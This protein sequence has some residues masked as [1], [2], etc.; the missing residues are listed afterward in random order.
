MTAIEFS[1]FMDYYSKVKQRTYK[2]IQKIP[3][4]KIDWT[5]REGKFT[6]GDLVRHMAAIERFMYAENAQFKPS[7]YSGCGKELADG[8]ESIV[9][10]FTEMNRQS[11]EIFRKLTTDDLNK[12][13]ITPAG[14][15]ITLWKWLRLMG[16]HEIHHRG[17]IFIYLS[18]LGVQTDPLY[19]LTSEQV[20]MRRSG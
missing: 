19:G 5:F 17:Q 10:F 2:I 8:Y 15:E 20:A 14:G 1:E 7:R 4:D 13:C 12:K 6:L 18:M 16:E 9:T 3:V 11:M